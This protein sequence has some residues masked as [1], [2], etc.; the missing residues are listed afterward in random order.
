MR[1]RWAFTSIVLLALLGHGIG[2]ARSTLPGADGL[3]FIRTAREFQLQPWTEVVRASDRHPLYPAL[4]A[5]VQPACQLIW[6]ASNLCWRIAAQF[7][8]AAAST[9]LLLP[10]F[11]WT[12]R[13]FGTSTALSAALLWAILPVPLRLGHEALADPLAWLAIAWILEGGTRWLESPRLS[14]AAAI[15]FA[16]GLGYLARPEVLIATACV[17]AAMLFRGCSLT[18]RNWP[19]RNNLAS[20]SFLTLIAV[21]PILG[22]ASV[23][24]ELSEKLS[25]RRIVGLSSRHD[26]SRPAP[27]P[28]PPGLDD[29]RW[30][31]SPKEEAAASPQ[32]PPHT[33]VLGI[34]WD[35]ADA[36]AFAPAL[37][38]LA[39]LCRGR[40]RSVT[41]VYA[42]AHLAVLV[43]HAALLGYHSQRHV[44]P[45]VLVS[46]PWAAAS[47][48]AI[49]DALARKCG[50]N[51][52]R[53]AHCRLACACALAC[54]GAVTPLLR[55]EH[56][57]RWG[58]AAAGR[59][60]ATH[61][62]ADQAILDTRGWA[63][64]LADRPAYDAWHIPQ[65]LTDS[66]L[67]YI[68]VG[69]DELDASSARSSTLRSIL[70]FA[71]QPVT[72][73]P[74]T[75]SQSRHDVQIYRFHPPASWEPLQP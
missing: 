66:R 1:T 12:R 24:G 16:S 30:D 48:L 50:W 75:P 5:F 35:W 38:T 27:Q 57:T 28:L 3:K 39:S 9:A 41:A 31:F 71:A 25:V 54:V 26:Q 29:P 52:H 11:L 64:F 72:G 47:G 42:V 32:L 40:A 73:F 19:S 46:I 55:P 49:L 33:A 7:V 4:V 43:R 70:A 59:W 68:V 65:A 67:A 6:P 20:C 60:L 51:P 8:S 56:P 14:L 15:G 44:I 17:A 22:Y 61:A 37:L 21:A 10:L 74:A 18:A 63:S 45:L 34:L 58:H 23:K 53:M 36:L 2:I 62:Q 13:A 69:V